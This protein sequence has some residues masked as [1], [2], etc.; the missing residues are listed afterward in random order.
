MTFSI[1]HKVNLDGGYNLV[2]GSSIVDPGGV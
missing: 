2:D 1:G